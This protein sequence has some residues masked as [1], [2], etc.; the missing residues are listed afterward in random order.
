[1]R[2]AC[3]VWE[4]ETLCVVEAFPASRGAV[5]RHRCCAVVRGCGR[6]AAPARVGRYAPRYCYQRDSMYRC[7]C[8]DCMHRLRGSPGS[9]HSFFDL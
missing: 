8:I 2:R 3:A 6:V 7:H 5:D 4:S 1:M 9:G